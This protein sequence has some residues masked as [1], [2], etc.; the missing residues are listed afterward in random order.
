MGLDLSSAGWGKDEYGDSTL[1][2]PT[3]R[4]E[5][6]VLAGY[7]IVPAFSV[8]AGL[9]WAMIEEI[10]VEAGAVVRYPGATSPFLGG[11]VGYMNTAGTSHW[12]RARGALGVEFEVSDT[13]VLGLD[14]LVAWQQT[15]GDDDTTDVIVPGL[16]FRARFRF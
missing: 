1:G 7:Q 2:A 12:V 10:V 6:R 5:V 11:W 13:V 9:D 14:A 4:P 15:F 16:E 8:E 3:P